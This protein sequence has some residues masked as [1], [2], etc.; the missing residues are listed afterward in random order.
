MTSSGILES[1]VWN[2]FIRRIHK[3]IRFY[4]D[5]SKQEYQTHDYLYD[6]GTW[7][8]LPANTPTPF[9]STLQSN[10]NGGINDA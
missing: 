5:S 2:A 7:S 3:V 10:L 4:A 8:E 6:S 1:P 9:K